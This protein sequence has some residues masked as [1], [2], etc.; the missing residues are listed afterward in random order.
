MRRKGTDVALVGYGTMVQTCLAAAEQLKAA[1]VEASV[2]DARHGSKPHAS[3]LCCLTHAAVPR[4][5][6]V[7]TGYCIRPAI[8]A[9]G[10]QR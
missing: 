9:R 7:P 2:M 4:H 1:G 10:S 3:F 6:S 5:C 8:G